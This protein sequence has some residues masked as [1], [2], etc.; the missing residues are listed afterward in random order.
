MPVDSTLCGAEKICHD[1]TGCVNIDLQI[2][3]Q[4]KNLSL[5]EA[6]VRIFQ[7]PDIKSIPVRT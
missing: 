4:V 2:Y 5:T 7:R 3:F 6:S 1:E